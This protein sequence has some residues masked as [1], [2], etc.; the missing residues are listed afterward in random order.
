MRQVSEQDIVTLSDGTIGLQ[1][2]DDMKRGDVVVSSSWHKYGDN[3][4]RGQYRVGNRQVAG[5]SLR[6]LKRLDPVV[7]NEDGIEV[8][9]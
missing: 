6:R 5:G 4:H 3:Y 9:E 8:A 7:C 1:H 2:A